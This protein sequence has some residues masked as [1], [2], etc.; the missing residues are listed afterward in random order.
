MK[1]HE[2]ATRKQYTKQKIQNAS[3]HSDPMAHIWTKLMG[4]D[5][6]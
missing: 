1:T 5:N 2:K 3:W 4:S 6:Q